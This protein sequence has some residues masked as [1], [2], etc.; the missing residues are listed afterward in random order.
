MLKLSYLA[1]LAC[2]SENP[3]TITIKS[4]CN[5]MYYRR[6][7]DGFLLFCHGNTNVVQYSG[8]FVVVSSCH[9][10]TKSGHR[11]KEVPDAT[12]GDTK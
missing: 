1:S 9:R 7:L 5:T 2:F 11:E 4:C 3:I 12:D 10:Q 6:V 8:M